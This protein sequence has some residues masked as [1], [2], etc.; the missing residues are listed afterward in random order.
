MKVQSLEYKPPFVDSFSATEFAESFE[1]FLDFV[2]FIDKTGEQIKAR[3]VLEGIFITYRS[4]RSGNDYRVIISLS[5]EEKK[6]VTRFEIIGEVND[7][8]IGKIGENKKLIGLSS[9]EN[10]DGLYMFEDTT[11]KFSHYPLHLIGEVLVAEL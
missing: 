8:L 6:A 11:H 4:T 3:L 9:P 5:A 7:L 10:Y 1:G 2:E